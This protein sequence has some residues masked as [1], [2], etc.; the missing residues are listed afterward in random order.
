[1]H[2]P[3]SA[4]MAVMSAFCL[5]RSSAKYKFWEGYPERRVCH[6]EFSSEGYLFLKFIFL[7]SVHLDYPHDSGVTMDS[8]GQGLC[9]WHT[10]VEYV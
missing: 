6:S 1:M 5:R 2:M 3:G 10:G 9:V 7:E 8:G 4:Q